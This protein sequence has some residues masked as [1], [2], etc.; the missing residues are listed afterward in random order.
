MGAEPKLEQINKR[1]GGE[2]M[3]TR[4]T[5]KYLEKFD[6]EWECERKEIKKYNRSREMVFF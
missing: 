4:T 2:E 5:E 1:V 3:E 6:Y